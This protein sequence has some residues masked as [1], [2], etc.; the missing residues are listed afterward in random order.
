M[1]EIR[2][3][4]VY[5]QSRAAAVLYAIAS[6]TAESFLQGTGLQA[7]E[8]GGHA[9]VNAAWFEYAESSIGPYREFSL[10]IVASRERL[11]LT[12]LANLL[13][14]RASGIGAFVVALPVD[15][16]LACAGGVALY[17]L[18]KSLLKLESSWQPSQLE[19]TISEQAQTILSMRLPLGVGLP[20]RIQQLLIF[21]RLAG[22]LLSTPI[23]TDWD[24]RLDLVGRPRLTVAD[25]SHTLGR[26]LT[27]LGLES[28]RSI[29]TVHGQLRYAK[30]PPP[31]LND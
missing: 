14:G 29:A 28:A 18:P 24:S 2:P 27:E 16:E 1:T 7:I 21:S 31:G 8:V 9:V 10:G 3:P 23:V 25:R 26:L 12:N 30:L 13:R 20:L 6:E 4:I 5:R 19:V 17:G 15:S 11:R 22:Q